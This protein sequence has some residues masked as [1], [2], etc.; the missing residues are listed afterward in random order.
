MDKITDILIP[1]DFSAPAKRA[2]E[3]AIHFVGTRPDKHLIVS[4]IQKERD[5]QAME[6]AFE[7]IRSGLTKAFRAKLS[8]K[9]ME[10]PSVSGLIAET[11]NQEADLVIMGT[12][13]SEDPDGTTKTSQTVL[14]ADCPVLVVPQHIPEDFRLSKI[15]LVL[16]PREIDDPSVLGTLL[17]VARTFNAKVYVLTIEHKPMTYGYSESEEYNED[18]LEYYLEGFYAQHIFLRSDDVVK[19]IFD[20]VA[21]KEIDMIAILPRNHVRH[22]TGSGGR[23]TR[24]LTLQTEIP[25]LAIEH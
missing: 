6:K 15:A 13:G 10:E 4:F 16:G 1:Y 24:I 17:D 25:L 9:A 5:Q 23:L 14:A 3:Y 18:L 22:E 21:E 19:A 8:W 20:Y 12:S 7:A 2:L 11:K